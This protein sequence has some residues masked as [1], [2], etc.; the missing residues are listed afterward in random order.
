MLYKQSTMAKLQLESDTIQVWFWSQKRIS[1]A[2]WLTLNLCRRFSQLLL[3][4]E[5]PL[6]VCLETSECS[7]RMQENTMPHTSW[8]MRSQFCWATWP[9]TWRTYF[10]SLLSQAVSDLLEWAFSLQVLISLEQNCTSWTHQVSFMSGRLLPL[11]ETLR[12]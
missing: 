8:L 12:P 1:K 3:M 2:F 10:K 6:Q 4:L 11:E 9:D 7:C 5:P